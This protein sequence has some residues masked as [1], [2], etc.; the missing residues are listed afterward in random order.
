MNGPE[1]R[2][3]QQGGHL[4]E[5]NGLKTQFFTDAGV[6]RAVDGVD[7]WVDSREILGVVGESGC[8]KTM[9]A[10]SIL[11]LVPKPG[12]IVS[13]RIVLDGV[14]LLALSESQMRDMRGKDVSMV[15]Q[16]PMV[17]LN[18]AFRVGSQIEEILATHRRTMGRGERRERVVELLRLV[19]IPSPEQRVRSYPHEISGGM[20]QRVM[21]AM[22]LACGN[23][24]LLIAD[25][26]TTALDVTIQAQI[27]EL[28]QKLL[29][30]LGMS[31][32]LITHDLGV[33]AETAHRV[34]VM[35]A[36]S[37]VETA[38]VTE[39]FRAPLHPYTR[40][41]LRSLPQAGKNGR[42]G[43]LYTIPGVVP[44]LLHLKPGCKFFD[45][46][47]YGVADV[48]LGTEP[49]LE[50]SA[51]EHKVRCRRIGEAAQEAEGG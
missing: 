31:V 45:R 20:R 11:R 34:V 16:E 48:C 1:P 27:L 42:K 50:T 41:L 33:V 36:G 18:P 12:R 47:P 49:D 44:N 2:S 7:L 40:G 23:P 8:G 38:S 9:T 25:E 28:F 17:S 29:R 21:I 10:R 6:V 37:V 15:F 5:I 4:L 24:K 46:C 3:L 51:P 43:S 19:G 30:D 39:L 26:P 13:G 22:A 32:M 14:D 35:Y